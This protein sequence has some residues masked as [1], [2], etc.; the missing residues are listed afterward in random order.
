MPSG[1]LSS[2]TSLPP[3]PSLFGGVIHQV[4]FRWVAQK[5]CRPG[6]STD[7]DD[8]DDD[9]SKYSR[10]L[11][12]LHNLTSHRTLH[13]LDPF[14]EVGDALDGGEGSEVV[15]ELLDGLDR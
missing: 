4:L 14:E 15:G 1:L 9:D 2:D 12:V 7:D 8:D 10:S 3:F 13:F 5:T 11:K 6:C